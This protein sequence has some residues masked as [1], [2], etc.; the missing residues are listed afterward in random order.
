[1]N[2]E[3]TTHNN[4]N[5]EETTQI[6]DNAT[7]SLNKGEE[8]Q[9]KPISSE[10]NHN[11]KS[12]NRIAKTTGG[13]TA[14]AILFG[15]GASIFVDMKGIPTFNRPDENG[16]QE[17]NP[18][19][20]E[21]SISHESISEALNQ[22]QETPEE[23]GETFEEAFSAARETMGPG[24]VFEWHGNIYATFL[25]DEWEEMTDNEK[26]EF[27]DNHNI[28]NP[29][30][31]THATTDLPVDTDDASIELDASTIQIGT[32]EE[33]ASSSIG[34]PEETL[35]EQANSHLTPEVTTESDIEVIS[36]GNSNQEES[37]IEILGVSHDSDTGFNIG[38]M[39]VDGQEVFV[40]D[41]DGDMVFDAM[42]MDL[43]GDGTI[44]ETEIFDIQGTGLSAID[45]GGLHATG[46]D[47]NQTGDNP[48]YLSDYTTE[49]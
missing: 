35:S 20:G 40:I 43:N 4:P 31:A 27:F 41:V 39:T 5:E 14:G 38:R 3:T 16:Q 42:A 24:S 9:N 28:A 15:S 1:M 11:K 10:I 48:D 23:I 8:K 12:A 36:V 44:D 7:S 30:R 45:L 25:K 18:I 17:E 34:N 22:L 37:D 19:Q 26:S 33:E 46:I 21:E 13:I 47:I 29:Y 49:G 2:S 32:N 6:T